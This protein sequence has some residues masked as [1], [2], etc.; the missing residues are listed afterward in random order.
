MKYKNSI[1]QDSPF[2]AVMEVKPLIASLE[3]VGL[4]IAE[5]LKNPMRLL[6]SKDSVQ[7][8]CQTSLG[9]A[10]DDI[11]AWGGGELEI[12]F[13]HRYLLDALRR[14]ESERFRFETS[15]PLAPCLLRPE[16]DEDVLFM[17]LPVRLKADV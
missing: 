11:P 17:V 9:K 12:G 10:Q 5:R 1:P 13:N 2:S 6:F 15:G 4:L 3:R 7:L 16:D 8:S 14:M